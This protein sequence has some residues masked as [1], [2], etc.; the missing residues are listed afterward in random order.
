L[1]DD[2]IE[3]YDVLE[4]WYDVSK[5]YDVVVVVRDEKRRGV[6]VVMKYDD[7]DFRYFHPLLLTMRRK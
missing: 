3:L 7:A 6:V 5:R 2:V 4:Y 1:Y